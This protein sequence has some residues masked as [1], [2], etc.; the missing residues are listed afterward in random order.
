MAYCTQ[1]DVQVAVG[2]AIKLAQLS[3]QDNL[4]AG[5]VNTSAVSAAIA[6]ACAEMD[7]YIGHRYAVPLSPVPLTVASK[8]AAWAARVLRR[9]AYNGQPLIDD[10]D[11]E[12]IDREWLDGVADG[13]ISLGI[14]PTPVKASIVNDKAGLRDP[15][16]IVSRLRLRGYA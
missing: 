16:L 6:E 3:D 11:R 7:S 12:K 4:L 5:G 8:A 2:G 9:N 14:E 10:I 15:T 13:T 1:A